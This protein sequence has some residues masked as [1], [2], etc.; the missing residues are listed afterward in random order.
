M[1]ASFAATALWRAK[2]LLKVTLA[3]P[4]VSTAIVSHC[5][6]Q[7]ALFGERIPDPLILQRQSILRGI[8]GKL[9]R[10]LLA[11]LQGAFVAGNRG[12]NIARFQ[13]CVT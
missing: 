12:G 3:I 7:I 5:P 2:W 10:P 8:F 1:G 13:L 6:L 4:A 11:H 9:L